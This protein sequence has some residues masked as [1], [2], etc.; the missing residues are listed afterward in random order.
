MPETR[1]AG[2]LIHYEW[3]GSPDPADPALVFLHDGLGAVGAWRGVPELIAARLGAR[4]LVYDRW[5]Y[6]RSDPRPDFPYAFMQA[7]VAPLAALL[8]QLGVARAHLV[9][10]SDGGSIALLLAAAQ[11]GRVLSLVT[12]AAHV[13]VEPET[14]AGIRALVALQQAGRTPGWLTRLHG[15]RAEPLLAAWCQGW[16]SAEH[17]RW[18]ITAELPRIRCPLLVVQGERDEY[19]TLAQVWA[20]QAGVPGAA[21]WTVPGCGHTP[22]AEAET[23]FVEHVTDF[24][25]PLI[26]VQ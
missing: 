15:Q 23:A 25:R 3:R 8:E 6:G 7:E 19:G 11:P 5:G 1:I 26:A 21:A 18:N 4:A 14:Q 13:F 24:L 9:G 16:L 2:H 22:H 10:H 12:E 17:A 20:I